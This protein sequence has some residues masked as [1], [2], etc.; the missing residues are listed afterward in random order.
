LSFS[1]LDYTEHYLFSF[2]RKSRF[3]TTNE[4]CFKFI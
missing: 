4:P 3:W 2:I 1:V